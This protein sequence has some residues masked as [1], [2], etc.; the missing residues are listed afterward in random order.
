M[1]SNQLQEARARETF[2]KDQ[3]KGVPVHSFDPHASPEEKAATAGKARDQLKDIRPKTLDPAK[4]SSHEHPKLTGP[5]LLPLFPELA[6]DAGNSDVIPTITVHGVETHTDEVATIVQPARTPGSIDAAPYVIP[7]WY[8]VGWRAA[9]GLDSPELQGEAKDTAILSAFLKEQY[10]GD[11]YHNAGLVF[12]VRPAL[13]LS[14]DQTQPI[15]PLDHVCH[16][17]HDPVPLRLGLVNPPACRL[18]HVLFHLYGSCKE[19]S[20][21]RHST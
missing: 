6:V 13:P 17:F 12:F 3:A 8:K 9:A 1:A 16:P 4:G 19:T 7:D 15:L 10:Y 5:H 21:R 2:Q 11:W 18:C 14:C 20:P